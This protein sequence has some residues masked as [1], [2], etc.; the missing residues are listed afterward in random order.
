[1][2]AISSYSFAS[3]TWHLLQAAPLVLWPQAINGL[4]TMDAEAQPHGSSSAVSN[5]FA[6]SLGLALATLGL[7][8]VV[9]TGSLPLTS[10]VE[11]DAT[12]SPYTTP[13]LLLTTLH[14]G[15][16]AFYCWARYAATS[17]TGY[18]LGFVGSAPLASFGLWC[19]L[20]AGT[21]AGSGRARVSGFP[22]RNAEADRKRKSKNKKGL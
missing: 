3:C 21:G 5:Y 9:L 22:F 6:R 7:L 10:M 12:P 15:S 13:V 2:D 16:A 20:F 8:T 4:L 18:V 1:M 11:N 19:L 14:H 17:Q